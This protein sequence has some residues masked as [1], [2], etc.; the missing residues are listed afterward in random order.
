MLYK[1]HQDKSREDASDAYVACSKNE[2]SSTRITWFPKLSK[3]LTQEIS[4][5]LFWKKSTLGPKNK[6]H[7]F[8][9]SLF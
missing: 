1:A 7:Q 3:I 6:I 5:S 8:N 4:M 2:K 9:T